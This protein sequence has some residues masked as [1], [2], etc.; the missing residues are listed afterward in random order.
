MSRKGFDYTEFKEYRKNFNHLYKEFQDWLYGFILKQ[1]LH[2][3]REVKPRTPVD[4]GDLRNHWELDPNI[5]RMGDVY[6]C[7]FTNVMEYA[8]YVEYGHA[9]PYKSGVG[10]GSIDWVDGYF[11]MTVSIEEVQR[12]MPKRF[13]NEFRLY[14]KELGLM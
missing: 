7:Y 1:G 6:H 4:T 9:K 12:K 2:F 10:P 5:V 14:L 11:M 8:S 3:I 13:D